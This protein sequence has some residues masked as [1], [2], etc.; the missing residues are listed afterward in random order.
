METKSN[1]DTMKYVQNK[2][3]FKHGLIILSE[4]RSGGTALL[5]KIESLV[6][7]Q[8]YS[9]WYIDA[10]VDGGQNIGRWRIIGF[11]GNPEASKREESWKLLKYLHQRDNLP[12][13]VVGDFNE[14]M[15]MSEKEGG[16]IRQ[17]KQMEIFRDAIDVC[18]LR[19][20]GYV[21]SKFTWRYIKRD[22]TQ[23][24]ERI[25]WDL[26][27]T[28]WSNLFPSAKVFHLSSSTSDHS[29]LSIHLDM[30]LMQ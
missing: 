1:L 11:Y 28:T 23:I 12:W 4:G 15:G 8:H 30:R 21:G 16:R 10:H 13:L 9:K 26:A 27:S 25:D 19:D 14:I 18:G 6:H 3:W 20:M 29:Q 7:I 22:G 24:R 17:A 2:I 5:W